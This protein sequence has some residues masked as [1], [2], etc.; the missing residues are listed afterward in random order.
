MCGCG[1]RRVLTDEEWERIFGEPE[2]EEA[3]IEVTEEFE[4]IEELEEV[5]VE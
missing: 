2:P 5:E 3:P 1:G 4:R